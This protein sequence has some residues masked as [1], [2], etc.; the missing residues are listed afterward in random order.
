[1]PKWTLR[2]LRLN[3]NLTQ[4]EFAEEFGISVGKTS[5]WENAIRFPDVPEIKKLEKFYGVDYSD[6][7]FLP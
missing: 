4:E 6:I 2:A 1:M 5:Q 7:N 3:R